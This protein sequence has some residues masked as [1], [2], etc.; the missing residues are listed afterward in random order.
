ML[1]QIKQY[2]K[3]ALGMGGPTTTI[4]D[5]AKDLI[6]RIREKKLTYLTDKKLLSLSGTCRDIEK[7][8]L[9]GLFLEAGCA[10][11]GSSILM[12]SIKSAQRPLL[13]Y[14]VFGMIPPPHR[15]GYGGCS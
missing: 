1:T 10:L 12:T 2:V 7:R 6:A 11:G 3:Q 5:G 9:D 8:N 15:D 13:I 4:P 14:D